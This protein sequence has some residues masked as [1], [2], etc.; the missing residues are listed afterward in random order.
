MVKVLI[1]DDSLV[2][3]K[4]LTSILEKV[5]YYVVGEANNGKTAVALYKELHPDIVTMDISMPSMNGIDAVDRIIEVDKEANIIMISAVNQKHMILKAI[6]K[7][8]KHFIIKPIEPEKVRKV[9]M[10]VME[11]DIMKKN[12]KTIEKTNVPNT[13][14]K[15]MILGEKKGFEIDNHDGVFI[16]EIKEEFSVADIKLLETLVEGLLFI[17]PLHLHF[18]FKEIETLAEHLLLGI[19]I[20]GNKAKEAKAEVRYITESEYIM[21]TLKKDV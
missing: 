20:L 10:E 14:T 2:M 6:S 11:K 17:K 15:E 1:V 13:A 21:K 3:R 19:V 7:G 8:A 9:F 18:D 5:G 16:I 4:N 12:T